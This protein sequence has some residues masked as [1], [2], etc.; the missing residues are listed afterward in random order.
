MGLARE[1]LL[2]WVVWVLRGAFHCCC[3]YLGDQMSLK[4]GNVG[5]QGKACSA[6]SQPWEDC[7]LLQGAL[8]M[9]PGRRYR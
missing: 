3:A 1:S 5:D 9:T 4:L 6:L 2:V 8:G 7:V